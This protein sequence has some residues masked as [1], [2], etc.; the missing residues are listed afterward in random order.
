MKL[1]V[2]LFGVDVRLKQEIFVEPASPALISVVK[3]LKDQRMEQL[4][5]FID[6]LLS[7]VGGSVILVN[8]RNFLS[9]DGW[10]TQIHEGDEITFMVPVAGG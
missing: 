2:H 4:E 1:I 6:D 10:K 8:G 9:L 7:S 5:R 3:G